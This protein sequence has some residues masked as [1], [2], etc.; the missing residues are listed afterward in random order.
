M[1]KQ[2]RVVLF[3]MLFVFFAWPL[4][5]AKNKDKKGQTEGSEWEVVFQF[6]QKGQGGKL[7]VLNS[8]TLGDEKYVPKHLRDDESFLIWFAPVRAMILAA[9]P[10]G[11]GKAFSKF[12][13]YRSR[14]DH[15]QLNIDA[16]L[17]E[18]PPDLPVGPSISKKRRIIQ[19]ILM[20]APMALGFVGS[21]L[22]APAM[23]GSGVVGTLFSGGGGSAADLYVIDGKVVKKPSDHLKLGSS[24]SWAAAYKNR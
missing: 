22:L 5:I 3:L 2:K 23:I 11:G 14:T 16:E 4:A 15:S 7:L 13:V 24:S 19:S 1:K 18:S 10:Y 6:P 8:E 21:G 20:A 9:E 12:A 17:V